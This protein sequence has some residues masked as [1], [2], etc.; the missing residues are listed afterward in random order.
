MYKER[1]RRK[2]ESDR[3][4]RERQREREREKWYFLRS[5]LLTSHGG[6][7]KQSVAAVH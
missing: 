6:D 4:Q 3:E 7:T 2:G 1:I 5:C